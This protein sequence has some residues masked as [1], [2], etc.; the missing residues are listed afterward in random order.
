[1][2]LLIGQK[3][4]KTKQ[5]ILKFW[6]SEKALKVRCMNQSAVGQDG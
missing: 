6:T 4:K 3:E 5:K 1:M 2:K